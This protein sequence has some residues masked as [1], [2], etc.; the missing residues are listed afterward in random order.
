MYINVFFTINLPFFIKFTSELQ[1]S[2]EKYFLHV[3]MEKNK[4]MFAF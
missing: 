4:K 2:K 1:I 3:V